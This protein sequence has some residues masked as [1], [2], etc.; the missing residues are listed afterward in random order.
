MIGGFLGFFINSIWYTIN[1]IVNLDHKIPLAGEPLKENFFNE[2]SHLINKKG[3]GENPGSSSKDSGSSSKNFGSFDKDSTDKS[4]GFDLKLLTKDELKQAIKEVDKLIVEGNDST[5]DELVDTLAG[6]E[7]ELEL[8]ELLEDIESSQAESSSK[9]ESSTKTK[10]SDQT[11]SLSQTENSD[12]EC[13]EKE[14]DYKGKG[15]GKG[16]AV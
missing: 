15:K 14:E 12:N 8:R 13:A 2:K 10:S 9:A 7:E 11:E 1:E 5:I 6:L 3:F 16:K 4:S